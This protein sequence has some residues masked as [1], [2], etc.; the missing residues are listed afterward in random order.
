MLRSSLVYSSLFSADAS[1]SSSVVQDFECAHRKMAQRVVLFCELSDLPQRIEQERRS[2]EK[3]EGNFSDWGGGRVMEMDCELC[4]GVNRK[5]RER[6]KPSRAY[7]FR[8]T[9]PSHID[10]RATSSSSSRSFQCVRARV[11][12]STEKARQVSMGSTSVVRRGFAFYE[13][14]LS[15]VCM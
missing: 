12:V 5:K 4:V 2:G 11:F 6:T 14:E 15:N 8:M 3:D 7:T 9:K 1:T 10:P 13:S